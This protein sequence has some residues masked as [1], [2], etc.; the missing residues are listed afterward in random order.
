[1]TSISTIL[2]QQ[3]QQTDY[4][5]HLHNGGGRSSRSSSE[6]SS[7]GE[8][9]PQL[10]GS[11][12][13]N[14]TMTAATAATTLPHKHHPSHHQ[15]HHHH[16]Q[17]Q[18]QHASLV[19]NSSLTAVNTA[20]NTQQQQSN[21]QHQHPQ[22]SHHHNHHQQQ[23]NDHIK[24]P[25]NAFM[26]WS[27]GQRR[28]MAQDN[29]KMHNSEIS[30]RLGAEWKLLTEGQ[31]RPFIDEAKRL[32]ALHM[33]EHPDY[34]YRP[35]RKPKTL[36]KSPVPGSGVNGA[37]KE[38]QQSHLGASAAAAAAAAVAVAAQHSHHA[39]HQQHSPTS[40]HHIVNAAKYGFGA[41]PLELTLN[42]PTRH[43]PG[44]FPTATALTHYPLDPTLALDLQ[45]RLQA[46]YA[47]SLYHPWRY[48]GCA[49]LIS[50][51][52]PPSPPSSNGTGSIA[53]S[54]GCGI[55]SAKSSPTLPLSAGTQ[56]PP[57]II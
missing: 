42:M 3:K 21:Q 51:E 43:L 30:K 36:N 32:R 48:F 55:K 27:R 49:P 4:R 46:M 41:T 1:M 52:A 23:Q 39:H 57:N 50:P 10:T 40:H 9:P 33:K 2:Q 15:H 35:R 16:Q 56:A 25:M 14:M 53:S 12:A 34:K 38:S 8:S 5:S 47:G 22:Q 24:R 26:V 18:Q 28:K 13:L 6:I 7:G 19:A 37:Q 11:D 44:A 29:P 54:Y 45:A 31:K 20:F 17:Q